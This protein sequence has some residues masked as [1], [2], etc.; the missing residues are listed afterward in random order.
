MPKLLIDES[1]GEI[2]QA[3]VMVAVEKAPAIIIDIDDVRLFHSEPKKLVEKIRTQAGFAVFDVSNEKGRKACRSHAANIIKCIAPALEASKRLAEDAKKVVKSDLE[4][5]K[6]F[7]AD[8]REIAEFHRKPL[9]EYEDEQ[10]RI[11]EEQEA[12]EAARLAEEK[13]LVDWDDALHLDELFTFRKEKERA[14][15]I[16]RAEAKAIEDKRLFDEAVAKQAESDRIKIQ[17]EER[18][19]VEAEQASKL[20]AERAK[21][22]AE[23]QAKIDEE[24]RLERIEFDKRQESERL[25][26]EE[27]QR[28]KSL[29]KEKQKETVA[30]IGRTLAR[31]SPGAYTPEGVLINSGIGEIIKDRPSDDEIL[32]AVAFYFNASEETVLT[33]FTSMDLERLCIK[34][35]A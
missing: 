26:A 22:R 8:V 23:E 20:E 11:Q 25:A 12:R 17:E 18:R 4:F 10:K 31:N 9:T 34:A 29:D 32:Q 27:L 1:T 19:K 13:Y 7:E 14:E 5:R 28:Q 16:A 6:T 15:E 35:E 21:V 3:N 2:L 30:A 33:W 24:R